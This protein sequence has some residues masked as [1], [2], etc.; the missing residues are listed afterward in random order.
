MIKDNNE[1]YKRIFL[2]SPPKE[3]ESNP[4]QDTEI[5]LRENTEGLKNVLNNRE[6]IGGPEARIL[7]IN[8]YRVRIRWLQK[9]NEKKETIK[10]NT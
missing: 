4:T 7:K 5:K 10:E 2:K 9:K 8:N 6:I 1:V 3:N